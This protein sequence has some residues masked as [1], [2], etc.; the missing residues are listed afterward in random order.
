MALNFPNQS[1]SFDP[2]RQSIR[3]TG[4]DGVF[5][6]SV[7]VQVDLLRRVTDKPMSDETLCLAAFDGMRKKVEGHVSKAYSR[8][9]GATLILTADDI[10]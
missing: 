5:E 10:K 3:F 1:R 7:F 4:Y 2:G 8:R 9:R 6:I